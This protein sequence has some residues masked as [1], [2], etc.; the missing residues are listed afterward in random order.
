MPAGILLHPTTPED[1]VPVGALPNLGATSARWLL[2]AGVSSFADLER[3]GA[4]A[5]W[6]RAQA[7]APGR[8]TRN[9]LW[10]LEG[11]LLELP[12]GGVPPERRQELQDEVAARS[13]ANPWST[14][15]SREAY[16]NPWIT[17]REDQVVRPDGSAGL[18][19][20][21]VPSL[22]TG[23]VA[24]DEAGSIVLVEQWRYPLGHG[25]WELVEGGTHDGETSLQAARRELAEEAGLQA[26]R[27]DRL[28]GEVALSNSIMAERALFWV[29]RDLAP[30]THEV[31]SDPTEELRVR[32]VPAQEA[33]GL[34]DDGTITDAMSVIGLN[35]WRQVLDG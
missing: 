25:S 33:F 10:A 26:G 2:R 16:A 7:I 8:V 29:A 22:A 12:V 3:V 28:G 5:A 13:A 21:V 11:A 18:Y 27:W 23:V 4:A 6:L 30:A 35:R 17:V 31:A 15:S 34:V 14:T 19:G 24:V 1:D 20:V 9:L 32:H